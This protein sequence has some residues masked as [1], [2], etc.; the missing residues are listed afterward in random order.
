MRA[1][2]IVLCVLGSLIGLFVG[3]CG[4]VVAGMGTASRTFEPVIMAAVVMSAGAAIMLVNFAL[5]G[6]V[7]RGHTA[8]R[9]K[10]FLSL[11]CLDFFVA[12]LALCIGSDPL[13]GAWL[14][15]PL[16]LKGL[17]TILLVLRGAQRPQ[18]Q[19][20]ERPDDSSE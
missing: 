11:A 1:L 16:A 14:A 17:L 13:A 19:A 12:Y 7:R 15:V 6:A 20:A 18:D 4:L 10:A 8:G 5:I 2:L 9:K 3:G